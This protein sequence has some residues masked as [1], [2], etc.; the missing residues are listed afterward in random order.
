MDLQ[1][2]R[3]PSQCYVALS[4]VQ[5]LSQVFII[6]K[7]HEDCAGW[8]VSQSALD[9]LDK[10]LQNA[11]NTQTEEED[12]ELE[13]MCLNVRSLRKHFRDVE[14]TVRGRQFSILCLQ[15][16]WLSNNDNVEDYQLENFTF[17]LTS[18]GRGKGIAPTTPVV[19]KSVIESAMMIVSLSS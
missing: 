4:R 2:S 5:E 19:L 9:E 7:L 14:Q 10:S 13:I 11:I 16:T 17:D 1:K 6:E 15:E 12:H 8:T 3:E 18:R